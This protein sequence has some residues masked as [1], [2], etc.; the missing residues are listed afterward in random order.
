MERK[1]LLAG[2]SG[3][4]SV[5]RLAAAA[6]L[7]QSRNSL[8]GSVFG[9]RDLGLFQSLLRLLYA[10]RLVQ[11]CPTEA[12]AGGQPVAR[13]ADQKDMA[14]GPRLGIAA[15]DL[16]DQHVPFFQQCARQ[17]QRLQSQSVA[18]DRAAAKRL[19]EGA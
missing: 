1:N 7:G 13:H 3:P 12:Q 15:V 4:G 18:R 19:L 14:G 11:L 2:A 17:S 16:S 8:P 5:W 10:R 9:A 6:R